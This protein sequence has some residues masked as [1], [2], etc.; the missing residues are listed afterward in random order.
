[1]SHIFFVFPPQLCYFNC[2]IEKKNPMQ[3]DSVA[4]TGCM[5]AGVVCRRCT[6]CQLDRFIPGIKRKQK[7]SFCCG[8]FIVDEDGFYVEGVTR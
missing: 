8:V 2:Q 4:A 5:N 6:K 3:Q 1:M 7:K